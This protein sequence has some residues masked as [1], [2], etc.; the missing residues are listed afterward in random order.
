MSLKIGDI[1]FTKKNGVNGEEQITL[2]PGINTED[3]RRSFV[4]VG[5]CIESSKWLGFAGIF[6]PCG[7]CSLCDPLYTLRTDVPISV[8][9]RTEK[10]QIYYP[11]DK[12]RTTSQEPSMFLR[13]HPDYENTQFNQTDFL[14][15]ERDNKR[16]PIVEMVCGSTA[17]IFGIEF[18]FNRY[19]ECTHLFLHYIRTV[20][21]DDSADDCLEGS[22]EKEQYLRVVQSE[23][24][25]QDEFE[26][27]YARGA[28]RT[29]RDEN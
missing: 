23:R 6:T 19:D 12:E 27:Y 16:G 3:G 22:N 5:K 10:G 1:R 24:R 8:S 9:F 21:P 13:P 17:L 26:S 28:K 4:I 18:W 15:Q 2:L 7:L 14:T 25:A 20:N 11:V 29:K